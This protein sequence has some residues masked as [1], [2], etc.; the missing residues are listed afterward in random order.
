[1]SPDESKQARNLALHWDYQRTAPFNPPLGMGTGTTVGTVIG[2][3][4]TSADPAKFWSQRPSSAHSGGFHVAFCGGSVKFLSEDIPYVLY[5]ALMTSN[6]STGGN[7]KEPGK[8]VAVN[9]T[10]SPMSVKDDDLK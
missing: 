6:G 8:N 9:S 1:M 2:L 4:Q 3:T 5:S 7:V 10:W